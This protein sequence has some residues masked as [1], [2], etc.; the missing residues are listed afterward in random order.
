MET[1]NDRSTGKGSFLDVI[2]TSKNLEKKLGKV[3]VADNVGSDHHPIYLDLHLKPLRKQITL[4]PKFIYGRADWKKFEVSVKNSMA[5]LAFLPINTTNLDIDIQVEKV[6]A[7]ITKASNDHIPLSK[8]RKASSRPYPTDVIEMIKKKTKLRKEFQITRSQQTKTAVND[9][10]REIKKRTKQVNKEMLEKDAERLSQTKPNSASFWK[11]FNKLQH[12]LQGTND[13]LPPL[14]IN[15]KDKR[16]KAAYTDVEKSDKFAQHLVQTFTTQEDPLFDEDFKEKVEDK[17]KELKEEMKN[18]PNIRPD[19]KL[20]KSFTM[21]EI[22]TSIKRCKNRKAAGIDK[23]QGEVIKQLPKEALVKLQDIFNQIVRTGHYPKSWKE[24]IIIMIHKKKKPKDEPKSY[25]PICIT[26]QLGKVFERVI[27]A[28]LILY[29]ETNGK[30]HKCQAGYRRGK[31]TVDQLVRLVS[32]I[33]EGFHLDQKNRKMTAALFLDMEKAFDS[34]WHNGLIYKLNDLGLK[35]PDLKLITSYLEDRVFQVRVNNCLSKKCKIKAGVPQGG[36]LS[37]ILFI[38]FTSDIPSEPLQR[39]D[40]KDSHFADDLCLWTIHSSPIVLS[41][42]LQVAAIHLSRWSNRWRMK[43]NPTKC[44]VVVFKKKQNKVKYD[45]PRVNVIIDGTAIENKPSEKFL[46]LTLDNQLTWN[47][48]FDNVNKACHHRL[49]TIQNLRW[50]KVIS[51]DMAVTLYNSMMY[52]KIEY[53]QPAWSNRNKTIQKK[54]QVIQNDALRTANRVTRRMHVRIDDLHQGS[55]MKQ[56]EDRT[57]LAAESYFNRK[58]LDP[59]LHEVMKNIN[60]PK[61][62]RIGWHKQMKNII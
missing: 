15:P 27:T 14:K 51:K 26:S 52:S 39:T 62:N 45:V 41:L 28:R 59:L 47:D 24:G 36:I 38:A 7:A 20:A 13:H 34:I 33:E 25:R 46:G 12:E 17:V 31:S 8:E 53:G 9:L 3:I 19:S 61:L 18:I 58:R 11:E 43:L 23:I 56:I 37:P 42:R 5:E 2:L 32:S 50:N 4:P 29:L 21:K 49:R 22:K 48:H 54:L 55:N 40:V 30:L 16:E 1:Y 6:T 35:M 44:S 60:N 57:M 10:T